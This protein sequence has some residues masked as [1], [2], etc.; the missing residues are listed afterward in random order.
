MHGPFKLTQSIKAAPFLAAMTLIENALADEY[1]RGREDGL[2]E[3]VM[4]ARELET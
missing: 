2:E 1:A 3:G 4:A